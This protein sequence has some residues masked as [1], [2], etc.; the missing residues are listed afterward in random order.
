MVSTGERRM[1][2]YWGFCN[3]GLPG[4][5]G[6]LLSF[7]SSPFYPTF[8]NASGL[9]FGVDAFVV[10]GDSPLMYEIIEAKEVVWCFYLMLKFQMF[11]IL[12]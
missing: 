11:G 8:L 12:N 3:S 2:I 1:V 6:V 10:L 4:L 7:I 9:S 5:I